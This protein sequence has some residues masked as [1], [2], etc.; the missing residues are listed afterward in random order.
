MTSGRK[1]P[2]PDAWRAA[3]DRIKIL[4]SIPAYPWRYL[5]GCT[6]EQQDL[7]VG[8]LFRTADLPD[9]SRWLGQVRELVSRQA[10]WMRG[11]RAQYPLCARYAGQFIGRTGQT[12][13]PVRSL[14]GGLIRAAGALSANAFI[15]RL[16]L[17]VG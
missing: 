9:T 14:G 11:D 5:H 13:R 3:R 16:A 8:R 15:R 4:A 1:D 17:A 7:F 2:H 10:L 6:L 12:V